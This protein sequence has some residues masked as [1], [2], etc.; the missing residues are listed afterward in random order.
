MPVCT[1][2]LQVRARSVALMMLWLTVPVVWQ[3]ICTSVVAV[4][5]ALSRVTEQC[6]LS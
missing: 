6:V 2:Y 5:L 1:F 3:S 4:L